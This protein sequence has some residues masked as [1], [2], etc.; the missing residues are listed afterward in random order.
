AG[1]FAVQNLDSAQRASLLAGRPGQGQRD[2]G[3][4]VCA[5]FGVG[6]NT[7]TTAIRAQQLT[8]PQAIGAAL[9][10]G[11]NCGSCVPELRQLIAQT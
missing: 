1:L 11:T 10:A 6:L 7:L 8:T 9:K 4:I 5:C 2:Q 3:R